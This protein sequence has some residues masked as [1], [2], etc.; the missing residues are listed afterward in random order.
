MASFLK[1]LSR[2]AAVLALYLAAGFALNEWA[3]DGPPYQPP[4]PASVLIAGA[5]HMRL[6]IDPAILG[7]A[8]NVAQ[9]GE[10]YFLTLGKLRYLLDSIPE[11]DT[12]LLGYTPL[13]L[14]TFNDRKLLDRRWAW[15]MFERFD[16]FVDW[17][18]LDGV[19]LDR[20]EL[21]VSRV[22]NRLFVSRR[23]AR[24]FVSWLESG[25]V[26]YPFIGGYEAFE[27]SRLSP[28][29][30][31]AVIE[32]H[33]RVNG[34]PAEASAV[35]VDYLWRIVRLC[36][37]REVQ[38]VLVATPLHPSYRALV[39]DGIAQAWRELM[40]LLAREP[41]VRVLDFTALIDEDRYF[42][43]CD[44]VNV[45][46]AAELSIRLRDELRSRRPPNLPEPG[47]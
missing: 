46:G 42:A 14:S 11:V 29:N 35:L 1:H 15:T 20:W 33:F 7:G 16:G 25:T 37:A 6:G 28:Q 27:G 12:V 45:D 40:D 31:E 18:E 24:S 41:G 2:F 21:A 44:H 3:F 9:N 38:L 10:P 32:R 4:E 47:P 26:L 17:K 19:P 5:S 13:D 39:P 36:Q 8:V 34:A 22:Q 30:L 23:A 43:N